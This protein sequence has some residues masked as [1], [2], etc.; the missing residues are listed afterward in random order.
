[1]ATILG[2][3]HRLLFL[4]NGRGIRLC[5][6]VMLY[7]IK[8]KIKHFF[9]GPCKDISKLLEQVFEINYLGGNVGWPHTDIFC[10]A[11]GT[12][13]VNLDGGGNVSH[14]IFFECIQ[15]RYGISKPINMDRGDEVF[16]LDGILIGC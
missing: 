10:H 13:N 1:M 15:G 3:V 11:W 7:G 9:V 8:I 12:R 16:S 5:I 2:R 14:V 6:D 4:S